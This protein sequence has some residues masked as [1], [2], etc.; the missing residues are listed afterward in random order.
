MP[1]NTL[2]K[3]ALT[4]GRYGQLALALVASLLVTLPGPAPAQA[5]YRIVGPDGKVTFS[6][7]PP[8][9][10]AKV[11][12]IEAAGTAPEAANPA[13]PYEL[14]LAADKYPA[15]LYTSKDCA[16]CDSG[17]SLLRTRGVPYSEKTITTNEDVESLQ[18]LTGTTSLPMLTLGGQQIKGFSDLEWTQYLTAAGYPAKSKLPS[19]YRNP[20]PSPLTTAQ[21]P[22]APTAP[23][24]SDASPSAPPVTL[25]PP[26]I[27]PGNPAGIQF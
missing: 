14:R 23:K 27:H 21:A 4:G 9:A 2:A 13:L 1:A 12:G 25:P 24:A 26:Q 10:A 15:T 18:R 8:A 11:T 3:P 6:D 22:A 7:K 16:P 5:V 17:R 20:P 19:S